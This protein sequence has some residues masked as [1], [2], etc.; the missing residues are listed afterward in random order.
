M[1]NK[2]DIKENFIIKYVKL[3]HIE[4]HNN[5]I[6]L[7]FYDENYYQNLSPIDKIVPK[8]NNNWYY[9]TYIN[10]KNVNTNNH[11]DFEVIPKNTAFIQNI[12]NTTKKYI[13]QARIYIKTLIN[14]HILLVPFKLIWIY[15]KNFIT[16]GREKEIISNR[17]INIIL[18]Y[19]LIQK[20]LII[21]ELIQIIYIVSK[22]HIFIWIYT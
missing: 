20:I 7:Y 13:K 22:N 8:K 6:K 15:H 11:K 16:E 1:I 5:K 9:T 21:T 17:D 10:A 4:I 14:T 3:K 19:I 18:K 12:F 2:N